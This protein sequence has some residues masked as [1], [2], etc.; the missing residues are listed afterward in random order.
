MSQTREDQARALK[1]LKRIAHLMDNAWVVPLLRI[2]VGL[3]SIIGL[4]PGAGDV[5]MAGVSLYSL[6]LA[7]KLGAPNHL[8]VRMLANV[9]LDLGLGVIPIVGDI[10][11]MFFKSNTRNVKLLTDFLE[12]KSH[13]T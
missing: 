9:A 2:R 12:N 3:D 4:V 7:R 6:H 5:A 11:D 13:H 1:R 8:M 10:F